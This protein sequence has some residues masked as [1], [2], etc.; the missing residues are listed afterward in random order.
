[1]FEDDEEGELVFG[2][3]GEVYDGTCLRL[4]PPSVL[5][6]RGCPSA[7][8][9]TGARKRSTRG[10]NPLPPS[11]GPLFPPLPPKLPKSRI[12]GNSFGADLEPPLETSP[13]QSEKPDLPST[14]NASLTPPP[15]GS[16]DVLLD[17]EEDQEEA[18]DEEGTESGNKEVVKP[19]I[20][21]E[22]ATEAVV[23]EEE[24]ARNAESHSRA[25]R[26]R[27][28]EALL[29]DDHLLPPEIRHISQQSTSRRS[30]NA[31]GDLEDERR[32]K[33]T[34]RDDIIL[35]DRAVGGGAVEKPRDPSWG[36]TMDTV[37]AA[38]RHEEEM[39]Q[40]AMEEEENEGEIEVEG[41]GEDEEDE[42][43]GQDITRCVCQ[44]DGEF[45]TTYRWGADDRSG[46]YFH[47]D[48]VR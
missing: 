28:E 4:I 3:Q 37:G 30:S 33:K 5:P 25:K 21:V 19:K 9:I 16:E 20:E 32:R 6:V 44:T 26:R 11:S 39:R 34:P 13:A 22:E 23:K 47:D 18:N 40:A 42:D 27:G 29:L 38:R 8:H 31:K 43:G 35:D 41:E 15:P 45:Y 48:F 12:S 17:D 1:M 10:R 24:L 14:S 46:Q 36:K 2:W 7:D